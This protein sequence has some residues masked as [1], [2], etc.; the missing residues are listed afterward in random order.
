MPKGVFLLIIA[1]FLL[2]CASGFSQTGSDSQDL[3]SPYSAQTFYEVA[4][5]LY[6][7]PV[8][9]SSAFE[10]AMVF[11]TAVVNLDNRAD[12]VLG[13]IIK[14][15]SG[16]MDKDYSDA[17]MVSLTNYVSET[18]DLE[19][20]KLGVRYFL[21]RLDS[22][23]ERERALG[24]LL[25]Q[26]GKSNSYLTSELLTQLG[27]LMAEKSDFLNAQNNLIE[28]V[29]TNPYN[30]LAF[31]K[32]VE[33]SSDPIH[34]GS[35]ASHLRSAIRSNPL[36]LDLA[37]DFAEYLDGLEIYDLA[38]GAYDY[39]V[40]LYEYLYPGE[41][42]NPSIY[43]PLAMTNYNSE[44]NQFRCLQI[45]KTIRDGGRF[46]ILLETIAGKAAMKMGDIAQAEQIFDR[47]EHKAQELL[48]DESFPDSVSS[49]Q[50]GWFYC[51]GSV[52]AENALAWA[53]R[54]YSANATSPSATAI[55][56]YSLMMNHQSQIAEPLINELYEDNQIAALVM[57]QL[58]L[59]QQDSDAG[60]ETLKKA[61][62]MDT[63]SLE[64]EVAKELL[65][66]NG[67][68][69]ISLE[70]PIIVT[71]SLEGV[72]GRRIVPEF[73]EPNQIMSMKLSLGSSRIPFGGKLDSYIVITNKWSEELVV[74]DDSMF[75][76]NIRID[77]EVKGDINVRIPNLISKKIHPS[78]P[79]AP[80]KLLFIPVELRTGRLKRILSDYPQAAIDIEFTVYLDPEVS[81]FGR[82]FSSIPGIAPI[83][84]SVARER[85]KLSSKYLQKRLDVLIKGRQGQKVRTL[86]LF[87]GLLR[88]Q[89][90][91]SQINPLYRYMYAEP[92]LLK[93]SLVW[94]LA[95]DDWVVK[96]QTLVSMMP[97]KLDYE[98]TNGVATNLNDTHWP[99]RMMALFLL[100]KSD[101]PQ[102]Q[103][104][105]NW[106]AKH[107][108]NEIVR[109]MASALGAVK[110]EEVQ[111]EASEQAASQ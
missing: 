63:G 30:R 48:S 53:N 16:H 24:D 101:S 33:I 111:P 44:R 98:L 107:D 2:F 110:P 52:D 28:A 23:E 66:E 71:K 39:C 59:A 74:S 73:T 46:D 76:G 20:A 15:A 10:Q 7:S 108:S 102:F 17:V 109:D 34:P 36:D 40:R 54:A 82:V 62:S 56:A 18:A 75:K 93:S 12:Y 31:N 50:L 49:E 6:N 41:V 88:E 90:V 69:Y 80:G 55:L 89:Q 79:V 57:G 67:S 91:M 64:A 78:S 38:G 84:L 21:E 65:L 106:A 35:Y 81:R 25:Q 96:L 27:L 43:L 3:F 60:I 37:L 61:I 42:L 95:D 51:F 86:K 45:A 72:F 87:A 1:A 68:E 11:F 4:Y 22:R 58:Q 9:E 5:E 47:I 70:E 14:V 94:G 92:A 8:A 13:D 29:Q 26:L 99:V 85:V 77:A 32:L 103:P 105:L 97:V 83:K 104:V 19:V 100:A